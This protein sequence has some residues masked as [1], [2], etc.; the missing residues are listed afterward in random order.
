[1]KP[2]LLIAALAGLTLLAGCAGNDVEPQYPPK[3]LGDFDA[4]VS[5][6]RAWREGAGDGLGR[7][8][9]PIAPARDG[10]AVFAA[11]VNGELFAFDAD[12]GETR[13][14]VELEVPVSSAL[15]AVA[16]EV[17]LGTRNG[18]V[19][20]IDQ[21]D[22]SVRWRARV[23]SEVLAAPQ[24][25]QQLLVVQGVD[26]SVTALDRTSGDQRWSY[27]AN[28]PSLTLRGT[29]T[30][31]VIDPVTFAGFANGRLVTLDNRSG[32]PLWEQR[33]AVAQGRSDIERLVDLAGQ[34][35]L[36]PDGRLFVT[37]YNGRLV[38]LEAT[39]GEPLWARE[40]SSFHTP[41]VVG[42]LLFVV[43]E[44]GRILALDV[45]SGDEV[46]RNAALEGRQPT[47]PAFADGHL[48]FGDFE[49]YLHLIDARSGELVGRERIDGSGISVR[50]VTDGNR[51]HVLANDGSLETLDLR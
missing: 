40:L 34:P 43:E 9:Y 50:P 17:Y 25:N 22:G 10:D 24:P 48:V 46:W 11:D 39:R 8:G 42:D 49:G 38:A 32:Q 31:T 30:P 16:G 18:E 13:W 4:R 12:D 1:M 29:G 47:S 6:E 21:D 5:L 28:L 20:A 37:S 15:T 41:I 23:P 51:I 3:E 2:T 26:G 36:T 35:V 7:A 19:L 45:D 33:I 14:E 44:S 27:S